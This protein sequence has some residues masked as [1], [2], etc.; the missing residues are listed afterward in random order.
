MPNYLQSPSWLLLFLFFIFENICN[1]NVLYS[2]NGINNLS[3]I[4]IYIEKWLS[5]IISSY[6]LNVIRTWFSYQLNT[7]KNILIHYTIVCKGSRLVKLSI[8]CCPI[9]Q[10]IVWCRSNG[11]GWNHS[12]GAS[13][14]EMVLRLTSLTFWTGFPVFCLFARYQINVNKID[15]MYSV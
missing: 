11:Y 2:I 1:P 7:N 6:N 13:Y 8:L 4:I 9:F 12:F 14:H 15:I 3:D 5:Y 10:F